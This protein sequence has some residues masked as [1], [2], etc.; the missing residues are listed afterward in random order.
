MPRMST[1]RPEPPL[2]KAERAHLAGEALAAVSTR[3]REARKRLRRDWAQLTPRARSELSRGVRELE[4]QQQ[5]LQE[6]VEANRP[7]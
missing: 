4:L 1:E 6:E 5:A 3:L 2:S 7:D